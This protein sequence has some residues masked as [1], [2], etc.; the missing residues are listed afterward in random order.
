MW[1]IRQINKVFPVWIAWLFIILDLVWELPQT[2]AG[3]VVKLV[4]LKCGSQEVDTGKLG[5]CLIQNWNIGGGVSLGW[6]Q[7]TPR[8]AGKDYCAHE[9]GHS[10]QSVMLGPLYLLVIGL[11]SILW[12]GFIHSYFMRNKSYYWFYT[13]RIADRIAGIK[14]R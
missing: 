5:K 8:N 12:A 6:F 10:V 1:T 9:V 14:D 2:L 11:P 4:F 7:F 3:A 13:E